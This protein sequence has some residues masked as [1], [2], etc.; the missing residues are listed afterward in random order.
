MYGKYREVPYILLHYKKFDDIPMHSKFCTLKPYSMNTNLG[1]PII[2]GCHM[3]SEMVTHA[4]I[5]MSV[6]L[7]RT[8]VASSAP[9]PMA[10][11][12]APVMGDMY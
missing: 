3:F 7:G 1:V 9:T 10:P 8:H 4:V 2:P 11:T 6:H 12:H 5:G